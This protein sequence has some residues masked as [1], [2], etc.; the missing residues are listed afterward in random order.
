MSF[1]RSFWG[2]L[3]FLFIFFFT[4]GA[5]VPG[6]VI[7]NQI[8]T[9]LGAASFVF[10]IFLAFFTVTAQTRLNTI[11]NALQMEG[12]GLLLLAQ[13]ARV[14]PVRTQ[15][16]LRE[17]IDTYLTSQIDYKLKDFYRSKPGFL[18]LYGAVVSLPSKTDAEVRMQEK[19]IDELHVMMKNRQMIESNVQAYLE[20]FEW[21]NLILLLIVTLACLL[22]LNDGTLFIQVV[23]ALLATTSVI[24]LWTLRDLDQLQWQEEV[25]IW[26]PLQRIF[27]ELGLLPYYSDQVLNEKRVAPVPGLIRVARYPAPY[28][29]MTGKVVKRVVLVREE[30][31]IRS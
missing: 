12:G 1:S 26:I 5:F 31:T 7:S 18:A 21:A 2:R 27:K 9:A 17:K 22:F 6:S 23:T 10:G 14:F 29:D 11:A 28:P 24:I 20:P 15:K 16:A 30:G 8:Q 3:L 19:M 4:L 25:R 13:A